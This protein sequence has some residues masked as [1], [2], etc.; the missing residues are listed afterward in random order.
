MKAGE[1][2]YCRKPGCGARR[3]CD[4]F[5]KWRLDA[6]LGTEALGGRDLLT[7]RQHRRAKADRY[8]KTARGRWNAGRAPSRRAARRAV[9]RTQHGD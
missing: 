3:G 1:E 2:R 5:R 6:R 7:G 8:R 4:S 9:E